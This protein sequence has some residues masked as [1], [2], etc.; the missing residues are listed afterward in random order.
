MVCF[1]SSLTVA[2]RVK[3]LLCCKNSRNSSSLKQIIWL[4]ESPRY[5]YHLNR[6]LRAEICMA[7]IIWIPTP[8]WA[9]D[10]WQVYCEIQ[11]NIKLKIKSGHKLKYLQ[12]EIILTNSHWSFLWH[13]FSAEDKFIL[14]WIPNTCNWLFHKNLIP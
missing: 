10:N 7:F 2:Q 6:N 12:A 4:P 1:V 13:L 11:L 3:S 8:S 5:P 9:S 14:L